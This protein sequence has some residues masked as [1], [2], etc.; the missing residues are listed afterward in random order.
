MIAITFDIR[1]KKY[2]SAKGASSNQGKKKPGT[3]AGLSD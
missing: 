3:K 2:S 1:D